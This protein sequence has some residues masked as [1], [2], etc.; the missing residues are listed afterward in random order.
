MSNLITSFTGAIYPI[1]V[2]RNNFPVLVRLPKLIE[3]IADFVFNAHSSTLIVASV[4]R[5]NNFNRCPICQEFVDR[6]LAGVSFPKPAQCSTKSRSFCSVLTTVF[7]TVEPTLF[8]DQSADMISGCAEL[9]TRKTKPVLFT[10]RI[11][12]R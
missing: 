9:R 1:D 2:I 12:N 11:A 5:S 6:V 8:R 3:T 10:G 7:E 4:F